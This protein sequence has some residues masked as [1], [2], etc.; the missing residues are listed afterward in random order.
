M[1]NKL[2]LA[3]IIGIVFI[4]MLTI[5]PFLFQDN[6]SSDDKKIETLT[7]LSN[8]LELYYFDNSQ[9]P[10]NLNEL[11]IYSKDHSRYISAVP[12]IA[13]PKNPS[14]NAISYQPTPSIKPYSGYILSIELKNKKYPGSQ[15]GLF[16]IK[17]KQ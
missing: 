9:Y 15:K 10:E 1:K 11:T 3:L 16:T 6:T 14:S 2:R 7:N 17:N 8:T 5:L 13:Q 12:F 4:L